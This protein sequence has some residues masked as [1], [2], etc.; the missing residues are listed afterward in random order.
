MNLFTY[1]SLGDSYTIGEG[2]LLQNNFPYQTVRL[3]RNKGVHVAAPEIIARTGWTTGELLEAME[4]FRFL[5]HY[6]FVTLLV[7]VNNQYR[8]LSMAEYKKELEH[9][10]QRAVVFTENSASRVALLSIPDYST[11]PFAK[12]L[13]I[14]KI[15]KE[16]IEYNT[17]N[18]QL[19]SRYNLHYLDFQDTVRA[20]D[21]SDFI[22]PDGLHP[23][24]KEYTIWA[25]KL[26][27]VIFFSTNQ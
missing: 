25:E 15:A 20:G 18:Q 24:E 12:D 8:G 11:T 17:L 19:A 9:L 10:I 5:P 14:N 23:S 27:E 22:A 3:L 2:V 13:D 21:R 7:G 4:D 1:L 16:I 6:D 26:S